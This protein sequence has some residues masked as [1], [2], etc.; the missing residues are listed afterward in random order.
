MMS[1]SWNRLAFVLDR[2]IYLASC[3]CLVPHLA[4]IISSKLVIATIVNMAGIEHSIIL[5]TLA[6]LSIIAK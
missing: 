4:K 3:L 6:K 1:Y 5:H 2:S